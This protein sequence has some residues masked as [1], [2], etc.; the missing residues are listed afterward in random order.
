MCIRDSRDAKKMY[1]DAKKFDDKQKLDQGWVDKRFSDSN[2]QWCHG[3][4]GVLISRLAQLKLNQEFK[5]LSIQ[6]ES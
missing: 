6:E 5:I 2:A 4:T 1:E 3:S